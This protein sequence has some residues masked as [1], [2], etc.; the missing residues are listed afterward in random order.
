MPVIPRD[1]HR[2][3]VHIFTPG[4]FYIASLSVSGVGTSSFVVDWSLSEGATGQV[5][6]GTTG[7]YGSTTTAETSYAY[8]THSQTV[9]GLA[10]STT[11]HY[12]VHS[13]NADGDEVYSDDQTVT[14][15]ADTVVGS[16]HYAPSPTG[17]DDTA[18]LNAWLANLPSG[19]ETTP[20]IGIFDPTD[21]Y[22]LTSSTDTQLYLR[23]KSY[24]YLYG[25]DP[26]NATGAV[27]ESTPRCTINNAS[28]T[29]FGDGSSCFRI[30]DWSYGACD[31]VKII[32]FHIVGTNTANYQTPQQYTAGK[33][34][35]MGV[36]MYS[37]GGQHDIEVAYNVI[38]YQWGHG[39]YVRTNVGQTQY[40]R[41][42]IHH[43]VIR[44]MG[45]MGV[46]V[47]NG[48]FIYIDDNEFYDTALYP[49]D[50][51]DAASPS[52]LEDIYVRRN[53]IED[54]VWTN[55]YAGPRGIFQVDAPSAIVTTRMTVTD[56]TFAGDY[57]ATYDPNWDHWRG[58]IEFLC[59]SGS[60]DFTITGNTSTVAKDGTQIRVHNVAGVTV[61]GN[62]MTGST[63]ARDGGA[64]NPDDMLTTSNCTSVTES[65]NTWL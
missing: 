15:G 35:A 61:T 28:A 23:S 17:G 49:I 11:Y 50:F 12:R 39:V 53:H 60:T 59:A 4:A 8:S 47:S 65:G 20:T 19:T 40:Q 58:M 52:T 16:Y 24:V 36:M 31:N 9:S 30:G 44:G 63:I 26:A 37:V 10:P 3:P 41:V 33:E 38:E 62:S 1:L 45:V 5:E 27:N 34:G 48:N 54:W 29:Q 32:G 64:D 51:E 56:N 7:S 6:Y 21:E 43:N 55:L 22:D 18:T 13:V 46:A 57:Y 42:N 14:T 25:M 2:T